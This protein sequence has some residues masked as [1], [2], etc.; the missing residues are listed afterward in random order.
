MK[1]I[2]L[3]NLMYLENEETYMHM[4]YRNLIGMASHPYTAVDVL[5]T[6]LDICTVTS[7]LSNVVVII[8]F[9]MVYTRFHMFS[10]ARNNLRA[11]AIRIEERIAAA[12]AGAHYAAV[13]RPN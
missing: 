2:Y 3:D 11:A 8:T 6:Y 12:G 1:R 9:H 13:N 5:C 10:G 7:I 4:T